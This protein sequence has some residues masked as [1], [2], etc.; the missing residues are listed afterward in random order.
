MYI[1]CMDMYIYLLL[2][3]QSLGDDMRKKDELLPT[4]KLID[5][6]HRLTVKDKVFN[7]LGEIRAKHR[8]WD[9]EAAI[10]WLL[11]QQGLWEEEEEVK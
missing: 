4:D 3:Y 8:L 1:V 2:P 10:I 9:R 7:V 5:H 11:Q 6:F